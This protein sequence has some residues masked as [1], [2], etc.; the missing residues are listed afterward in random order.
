M[1]KQKNKK[2]KK[3]KT[4]SVL[5]IVLIIILSIGIGGVLFI[6]PIF[7][8]EEILINGNKALSTQK[9]KQIAE[10]NIGD[11]IFSKIGIIMKVKL[12]ENGYIEDVK[13]NKIYPNKVTFEIVE[14]NNDFQIQTET[15]KYVYIDEQGHILNNSTDKLQIPTIIGMEITENDVQT[16]SRLSQNDLDKMETILQIREEFRKINIAEK[17]TQIEVKNEYIMSLGNEGI[18]INLGDATNLKNRMYYVKAILKQ[19][20]GNRGTIYVNGNLNEGFSTYFSAE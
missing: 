13:I 18:I 11:N 2:R 3:K 12:K 16:I 9:I 5:L 19:E 20:E 17:I 7:R 4:K 1:S 6:S 10:I 8:I 15:G 14:R